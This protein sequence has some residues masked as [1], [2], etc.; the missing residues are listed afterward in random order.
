M[1]STLLLT[2][3][4]ALTALPEA[5]AAD[6]LPNCGHPMAPTAACCGVVVV[7][8]RDGQCNGHDGGVVKTDGQDG[9]RAEVYV[10]LADDS[11]NGGDGSKDGNGGDT[12]NDGVTIIVGDDNCNGGDGGPG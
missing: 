10:I 1:K 7:V 9:C 2:F 11:C 6:P 8:V 12:C 4:F 5:S 3:L